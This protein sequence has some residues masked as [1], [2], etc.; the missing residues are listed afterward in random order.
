[1]DSSL[2]VHP[3]IQL[4]AKARNHS[5]RARKGNKNGRT[6]TPEKI[7]EEANEHVTELINQTA[8]GKN[9][10]KSISE[11]HPAD[12]AQ[13][14]ANRSKEQF[15]ALF[16]LFDKE[17]QEEI[18]EHLPESLTASILRIVD[19][20]QRTA[21][22]EN[23]SMDDISD[24]ADF[25]TDEELKH[26]FS[27]LRKKTREKVIKLLKL[28]QNS[29]GTVMDINTVSLHEDFTV[30]KS[31]QILQRLGPDQEIKK[32]IYITDKHNKLT[33]Q[34]GL[35]DLVLHKPHVKIKEFMKAN[36]HVAQVNEDQEEVSQKMRHYQITSAPVVGRGNYFLGAVTAETLVDILE[37]EASEDI[38]RISAMANL[39]HTYFETPF[40]RL[41][42]ERGAILIVL[43]VAESFTSIIINHY[44]TLLVGA[45]YLFIP[46]LISTG[47][48]TS[49]QTSAIVVQ[50]LASGEIDPSNTKRFLKREILM[51][52]CLALLLGIGA[53]LRV[54]Y[55]GQ[56]SIIISGAV[57]TSIAAVVMLSV[58]LG[59]AV[60][61]VLRKIG[62]DPAYSAAP[63]LATGM[64]ICGLFM[65]CYISKMILSL[66]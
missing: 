35:E 32:T 52:A 16:L 3:S 45:L 42:F 14:I 64:D 48:N 49:T 19:N 27:L 37:E 63:F 59:S 31:I 46:M 43:M 21:F 18:I 51:S 56:K 2:S 65:Y 36:E 40:F 22:L 6:M 28:K 24:L 11:I 44:E 39:K 50:G 26:Y 34:I 7:L 13:F 58:L 23:M 4:R 30:E 53:F 60:P 10:L 66:A 57:G 55:I 62:L 17:M 5:G 61:F 33:G 54:F 29:V 41:L 9:L 1:M 8:Q 38:L 12:I 25:T 15:E 47:G 20:D